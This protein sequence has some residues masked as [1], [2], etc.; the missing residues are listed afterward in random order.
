[1]TFRPTHAV[2]LCV[3]A[4]SLATFAC[5]GEGGEKKAAAPVSAA[6]SAAASDAPAAK[7]AG[8]P[9]GDTFE[10]ALAC[11]EKGRVNRGCDGYAQLSQTVN[12]QR[13]D[14]EVVKALLAAAEGQDP[15]RKSLALTLLSRP[16]PE[17]GDAAARLLTLLTAE[18]EAQS[19]ADLLDALTPR[20]GAGVPEAALKLLANPAEDPTVRAGA[21]RL[22]GSKAHEGLAEQSKPALLKALREDQ[23]PAVRRNAATSLGNLAYADALPDLIKALDDQ[24]VAPAATFA[25]ARFEVPE[26]YDAIWSRIEASADPKGDTKVSLPLLASI[27]LL[28]HHPKHDAKKEQKILEKLKKALEKRAAADGTA[29]AALKLIERNLDRLTGKSPAGG[30]PIAPAAP[31]SA[32]GLKAGAPASKSSAAH[33]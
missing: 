22:L 17:E 16:F 2:R 6:A 25:L 5:H 9:L 15:A 13:R 3:A 26:A 28:E 31:G 11:V 24:L 21:A 4:L 1:M 32:G 29:Q 30:A 18:K 27:R 12:T 23:A 19:K 8:G 33:K 14:P 7:P 20:T 10:K